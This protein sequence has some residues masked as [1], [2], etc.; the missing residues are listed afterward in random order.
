MTSDE[1]R[2]LYTGEVFHRRLG[3]AA[4]AFRYPALFLCFPLSRR[5]SLA[6]ALFG[7]NRFNLFGFHEADHGD[8]RDAEA[9]IRGVLADAG[10]S[11]LAD[12][13][14]WLQT[15]P[16]VLGFVFNPV[17]FWYGHD[18]AGG[19][20]VVLAEVNNTFGERHRY[21][22]TAPDQGV[23][24]DGAELQ[25]R[26]LFHVSPFFPV[27][28]E[29]RFRFHRRDDRLTVSIRYDRAGEPVLKTV[30]TGQPRPLTPPELLKALA[31]HG[32]STLLVVFRIH[33]QALKLWRKGAVFHRKP[34]PPTL[35]ISS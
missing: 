14:V 6:N 27:D 23:I 25:C 5:A 11:G 34:S 13:E 9:W 35:E 20:R 21:L 15:Q 7:Y 12:G 8:G 28:G 17:S 18:S 30:L 31:A 24:G 32:W 2:W 33:L 10:L 19:L 26:K 1:R 29:Y 16:R 4:H 3:H 22:L